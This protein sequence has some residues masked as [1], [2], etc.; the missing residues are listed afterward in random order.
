MKKKTMINVIST[1]DRMFMDHL[2]QQRDAD[3]TCTFN[4]DRRQ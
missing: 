1:L 4:W 2:N 3:K